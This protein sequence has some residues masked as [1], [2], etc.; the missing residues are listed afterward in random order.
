MCKHGCQ[1]EKTF[2]FHLRMLPA[3]LEKEEVQGSLP[4]IGAGQYL[5]YNLLLV[6]IHQGMKYFPTASP[7]VHVLKVWSLA[8]DAIKR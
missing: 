1:E 5:V 7:K 3:T 2:G 4:L 6:W 8:S